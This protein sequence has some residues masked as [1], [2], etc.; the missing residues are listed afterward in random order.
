MATTFN[1]F[2]PFNCFGEDKKQRAVYL[3]PDYVVS[4]THTQ[5]PELGEVLIIDT[6]RGTF[7]AAA[8]KPQSQD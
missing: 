4:A 3:N 5:H 1:D 8:Q 6:T 2:L 7:V